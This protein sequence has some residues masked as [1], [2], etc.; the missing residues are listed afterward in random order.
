MPLACRQHVHIPL[1][2]Q[3]C[4]AGA[5]H[6]C[7]PQW[8]GGTRFC[9]TSI[10]LPLAAGTRDAHCRALSISGT[11]MTK[12]PPSCSLVSANGPSCTCCLPLLSFSVVAV[13]T[14]LRPAPL[15][16]TPASCKACM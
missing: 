14:G 5:A 10:T 16:N 13:C 1:L 11:L 2:E 8:V 6:P 15:T 9:R 4:A 12:K 3:D 7:L